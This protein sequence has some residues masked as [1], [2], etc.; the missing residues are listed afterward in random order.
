MYDKTV[1]LCVV[2]RATSVK[3]VVLL[4]VKTAKFLAVRV[5]HLGWKSFL[6]FICELN[7]DQIVNIKITVQF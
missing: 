5:K 2:I 4:S 7:F 1:P 3:I 6:K